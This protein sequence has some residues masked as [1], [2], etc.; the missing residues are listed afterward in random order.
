M[1]I[2]DY[3]KIQPG[4]ALIWGEPS[5]VGGPTPTHDMTLSGLAD[6]ASRQGV[7]ADLGPQWDEEQAVWLYV[8]TG[9]APTA[10]EPADLFFATAR[11]ASGEWP[12][13]ITGTDA[14][15]QATAAAND[16]HVQQLEWLTT[17]SAVVAANAI[18]RLGA[19]VIW[20]PPH[21]YIAP[22]VYNRLGVAFRANGTSHGSRVIV[23]PRRLLRQDTAT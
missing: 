1:A 7:S 22:V 11:T 16:E 8:E 6:G 23:I 20:R 15:F 12:V 19:P 10:N 3:F 5:A 9:T 18:Q 17:L 2:L 14:A 21:Q 4:T 13:D